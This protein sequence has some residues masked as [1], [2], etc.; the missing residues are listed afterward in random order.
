MYYK[1]IVERKKKMKY[2]EGGGNNNFSLF[3]ICIPK[4]IHFHLSPIHRCVKYLI[5]V[6]FHSLLKYL[7]FRRVESV[8]ITNSVSKQSSRKRY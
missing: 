3:S 4:T 2:W 7:S 5:S 6:Y 1:I 8:E